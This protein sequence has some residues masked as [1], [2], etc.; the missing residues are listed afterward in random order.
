MAPRPRW[1]HMLQ[2]S[3]NEARL[4]VDLYNRSGQERQLEAFVVHMNLAWLKLLQASAEKNGGDLYIRDARGRRVRHAED[5][6]WKHR[7]LSSLL[8]DRFDQHDPVR[9]NIEF[10]VAIRNRIEHRYERDIASLVAGKTQSLLLNYENAVVHDFGTD[11]GLAQELRFPL[12]MSV[13]TDS[14]IEAAKRVR[15]RVPKSV[16]EWVQDFETGLQPETL[17]DQQFE[18]RVYLVPHT[19]PRSTADAS[20]SFI[21]ADEL[22][23]EQSDALDRFQTIIREKNVPVEDLGK[24]L[25]KEVM[26]KVNAR[27][28]VNF[29]MHAHTQAWRYFDVRPPAGSVNPARTKPQFCHYNAAFGGYAYTPAWVDYLVRKVSDPSTYADI[30][31]WQPSTESPQQRP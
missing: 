6:D 17:A 15:S 19:G 16:L 31:A 14:A 12:F 18:F 10:F 8:N 7:P 23:P 26:E 27:V 21:R 30:L 3:K 4:A 1:W 11:E 25:P 29:T 24:L 2:A 13:L 9:R 22:S 28:G 5:G 20:M